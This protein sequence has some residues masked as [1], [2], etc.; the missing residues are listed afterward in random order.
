[1][2]GGGVNQSLAPLLVR[3]LSGNWARTGRG[4]R[5]KR[6]GLFHHNGAAPTSSGFTKIEFQFNKYIPLGVNQSHIILWFVILFNNSSL[7]YLMC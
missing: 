2:G 6:P 4:S 7:L 5:C 1:M 3:H